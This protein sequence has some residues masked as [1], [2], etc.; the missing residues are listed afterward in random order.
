MFRF[1]ARIIIALFSSLGLI[2]KLINFESQEINVSSVLSE[3]L[4]LSLK[5]IGGDKESNPN[6]NEAEVS[7]S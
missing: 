3:I 6:L 2:V 7:K 1:C 4:F 5:I